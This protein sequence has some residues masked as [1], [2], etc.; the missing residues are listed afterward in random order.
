MKSEQ[1]IS[2]E[3]I[4]IGID[5]S[6]DKLDIFIDGRDEHFTC[7]NQIK[8]L[9]K[10]AKRFKKIFPVLIVM[11]ATGGYETAAAIVFGEAE[12]P[13]AIVFP[14]RVRQFALGLGINAK[15]DD[16]DARVLA[17]YGRVAGISPVPIASKELR[18]LAALTNR[19]QQLIEMLRAE[20]YRLDM[21]E[22]TSRRGIRKHIRFLEREIAAAE[23]EIQSQ[24]KECPAWNQTDIL[25]QSVPGVGP[26]LSATLITHLPEL[27]HLSRRKIAALVGVAPFA[28]DTGKSFGKRFCKG[29]RNSIRRVL[30]MA[31][32][33][34]SRFNPVIKAH[35]ESLCN[36]G[37]LKKVA[38]IACARKLLV[39][40]NAMTRTKT[41]W[42]SGTEAH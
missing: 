37:K 40:L 42:L 8:H 17:Y 18:T 21:F 28:R 26:V 1:H 19:R 29:G 41:P 7:S 14:R 32:I 4:V 27:G 35:Y 16:I 36:R 30:Y 23:T 13:F 3:K 10:L 2:S 33:S 9:Q 12:L 15:T 25:L 38:L 5:V 34:A 31:T 20:Q 22:D 11:E 6:K 24:I 39:I